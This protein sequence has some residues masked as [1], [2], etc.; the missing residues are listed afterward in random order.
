MGNGTIL[1]AY[2]V[3]INETFQIGQSP[4]ILPHQE[5][6]N[7]T[8]IVGSFRVVLLVDKS[9][10]SVSNDFMNAFVNRQSGVLSYIIYGWSFVILLATIGLS[11]V[12]GNYIFYNL[13][14]LSEKV[15]QYT[16]N[17]KKIHETILELKE[18]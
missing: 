14:T 10:M 18:L 5:L 6:M 11:I 16:R 7:M 4:F 15:E 3:A 9:E 13:K 1:N 17:P 2:V 8:N 12:A